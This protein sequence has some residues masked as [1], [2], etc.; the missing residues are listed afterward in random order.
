MNSD[1]VGRLLELSD[2][3]KEQKKRFTAAMVANGFVVKNVFELVNGYVGWNNGYTAVPWYLFETQHGL[4]KVGWRKRVISV[5][6]DTTPLR[7]VRPADPDVTATETMFHAWDYPKL[8][9][10]LGLLKQAFERK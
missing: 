9:E 6:W 1:Q 5:E 4:I 7:W 10:Y 2:A 3:A 8:N